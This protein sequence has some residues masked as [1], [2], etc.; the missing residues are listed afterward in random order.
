MVRMDKATGVVWHKGPGGADPPLAVGA[1]VVCDIDAARRELYARV[2]SAGHLLDAAMAAAGC[3]LVPAK[4]YHFSPGSYVEYAGK[5]DAEQREQL[6][7][8]LATEL[9]RLV[10]EAS[11]TRVWKG[12]DGLR[13]VSVGGAVCPCGG[14]HVR[15][16]ADIGKVSVDGIKVKGK[17]TRVSYSLI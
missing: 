2:H 4:G 17:V 13:M 6:L 15:S 8:R 7:P 11:A 9:D 12:E 10:S 1:C 16:A 14:T 3:A 5:L